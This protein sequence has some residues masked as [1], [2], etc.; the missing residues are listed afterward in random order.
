[1]IWR[2]EEIAIVVLNHILFLVQIL[3]DIYSA[4]SLMSE[5]CLLMKVPLSG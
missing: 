2:T 1:M 5:K 4:E 3:G